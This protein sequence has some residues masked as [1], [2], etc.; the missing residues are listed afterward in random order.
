MFTYLG[1]KGKEKDVKLPDELR[2]FNDTKRKS[3]RF[4][5]RFDSSTARNCTVGNG[6]KSVTRNGSYESAVRGD[7]PF[8]DGDNYIEVELQGETS[9]SGSFVFGV[10]PKASTVSQTCFTS[11]AW[12]LDIWHGHIR[13]LSSTQDVTGLKGNSMQKEFS[14]NCE[15]KHLGM[16]YKASGKGGGTLSWTLEGAEIAGAS[17]VIPSS[18]LPENLVPFFG[19][20]GRCRGARIVDEY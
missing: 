10:I 17:V 19:V 18:Y 13:S 4:E 1:R 15:G 20:Y 12:Y 14:D 2:E 8:N 9:W 3:A 11:E 7:I 16:L 6:G 5:V